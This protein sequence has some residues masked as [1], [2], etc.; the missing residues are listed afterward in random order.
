MILYH[1]ILAAMEE[2]DFIEFKPQRRF[3]LILNMGDGKGILWR[4]G[5]VMSG[6][7]SF[8]LKNYIDR[9]FMAKFQVSGEVRES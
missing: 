9:R 3:L 8:L 2:G 4:G 7:I 6:R 1:N 5:F